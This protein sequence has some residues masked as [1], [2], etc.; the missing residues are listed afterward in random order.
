MTKLYISLSLL[1]V[2]IFFIR[3]G[4]G[5]ATIQVTVTSVQT[6]SPV[7][8]DN[9]FL[10]ITGASDFVWEYTAT[11][12]T[13]GYTNNNPALF[14]IFD[15]NYTNTSGNGPINFAANA[16]FFDRQYICPL[17]IPT[18]INL[19][20]EAYENDDAGNYDIIGN[21]DGAT[22]I[23]NVSMPIP[24]AAGTLNYSFNA[25]GSAGCPAAVNYT[26]NLSV[27]RIDFAPTV[28]ILPDNICDAQ[29]VNLNT[30]YNVALC[31][32]NTLEANEPRAGDVNSNQSSAW[33][34][35]IAPATGEV[36]ITTDLAATEIGTYFQIYH[37][38]D[39]GACTSGLQPLTNAVIKN[40]FEY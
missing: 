15:F 21:T 40:K 32:S 3:D 27:Q 37:A 5:Q 26:I 39:G 36:T 12:N 2:A 35:F 16:L 28:I 25:S 23:Q 10:D 7:D 22:G 17:D 24:P 38:A 9:L 29:P 20:W 33:L 13:L 30:S 18:S 14:G 31:Q 34:K 8:C 6:S 4:F 1:F 11:D 19:A